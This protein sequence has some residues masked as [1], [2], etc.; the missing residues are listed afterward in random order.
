MKVKPKSVLK[1]V[2]VSTVSPEKI[3]GQAPYKEKG[4]TRSCVT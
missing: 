2:V 3:R 1:K 4:L